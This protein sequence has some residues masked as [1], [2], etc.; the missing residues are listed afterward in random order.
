MAI[1]TVLDRIDP[2]WKA[3]LDL[4]SLVLEDELARAVGG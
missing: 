3:D 2:D 1:A 4:G